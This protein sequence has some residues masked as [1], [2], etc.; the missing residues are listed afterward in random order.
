VPALAMLPLTVAPL[1]VMHWT[2]VPDGLL[3]PL[4]V[5][6]TVTHAASAAGVP[7][8][9]S[10]AAAELDASS[11]RSAPGGIGS[12]PGRRRGPARLLASEATNAPLHSQRIAAESLSND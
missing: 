5:P 11:R 9:I 8:P 6:V 2:V 4:D 12:R 7:P 1:T 3:K 10:S